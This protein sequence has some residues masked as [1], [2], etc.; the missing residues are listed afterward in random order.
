MKYLGIFIDS[1]LKWHNHIKYMLNKLTISARILFTMRHY[2][3]KPSLLKITTALYI[4]SLS[5]EL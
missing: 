4:F 2:V 5:M 3:N 1:N